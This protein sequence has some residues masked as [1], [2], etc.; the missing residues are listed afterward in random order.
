MDAV[1]SYSDPPF[2]PPADIVIDLP[3]PPSV[4]RTRKMDFASLR[5]VNAWKNVAN[6]YVLAAKGRKISPLK[7]TKV[8]RF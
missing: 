8:S 2:A 1:T 6:G 5:V 7:L 4:N 3:A